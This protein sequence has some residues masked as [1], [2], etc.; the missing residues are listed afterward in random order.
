MTVA[1]DPAA[2]TTWLEGYKAAWETR[3]PDAAAA[4]FTEDATYREMPYAPAFEGREAIHAY[5]AK[6]TSGQKGVTFTYE[7]IA[8]AGN[9]GVCQWH[10]AFTAVPGGEAI[11]LDGIFRCRFAEPGKVGTF[12]EWWHIQVVPAAA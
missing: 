11:D 12:E 1:L 9:E 8:C 4:L 7:V 5:W 2:F 10:A 3:D 6:V